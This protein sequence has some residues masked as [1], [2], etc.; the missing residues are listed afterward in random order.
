MDSSTILLL[1]LGALFLVALPFFFVRVVIGTLMALWSWAP[2]IMLVCAA[3]V[4]I[5]MY[6]PGSV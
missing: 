3:F 2:V 6:F 1:V 5:V 4:V